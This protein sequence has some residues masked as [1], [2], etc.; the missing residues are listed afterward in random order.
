MGSHETVRFRGRVIAATNRST[1]Q[2]RG[3]DGFREDFYYRLCSDTITIPPL[4]Q[5]LREEPKE[6]DSLLE[7]IVRRIVG[8]AATEL[9]PLVHAGLKELIRRDYDWPGNVR[10]LEQAVRR[11][12]VTRSYTPENGAQT[13]DRVQQLAAAV[14]AG[15]I[16]ADALL[17]AY[18]KLL[19][20]R[21]GNLEEVARRTDLDR[22]TVKRHLAQALPSGSTATSL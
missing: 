5:R 19:Y 2:L 8:D 17:T 1:E 3:K 18:C 20:E 15:N 11:I 9:L 10:E 16:T 21:H 7:H 14:N 12:L 13:E 4:R 22:R 6:L